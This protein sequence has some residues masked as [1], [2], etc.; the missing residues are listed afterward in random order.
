MKP[1]DILTAVNVGG[2]SNR[3]RRWLSF[4]L[5]WE[6]DLD[7]DGQ[8]QSETLGDGAGTTFAGLTSRDDGLTEDP[9]ALWVATTYLEKYWIPSQ[10]EI[11][12][13]PVGE[14]VANYAVNCGIRRASHFLQTS[15]SDYGVSLNLDGQIGPQTIKAAWHVPN[16]KELALA[17]IAK[18][19]TYYNAIA[20][21]NR[22]QWLRGWINR[23]KSLRNTFCV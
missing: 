11:L 1:E 19:Q 20:L 18:S 21:D 9:T 6:C 12:P 3:F 22:Q 8:I 15:L 17:V 13:L 23:N 10:A 14:V 16:A 5:A 7:H 4:I 2:F